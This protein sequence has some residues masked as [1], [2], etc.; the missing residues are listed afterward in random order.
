[1]YRLTLLVVALLVILACGGGGGGVV[2]V[3][4][5]TVVSISPKSPTVGLC[6]TQNFRATVT[7]NS[8]TRVQFTTSA[9]DISQSGSD[10]RFTA[11]STSG[12]VNVTARSVADTS[13][14]DTARV[15]VADLADSTGRVIDSLTGDGIPGIE[16]I[17]RNTSNT[18]VARLVTNAS[19]QYQGRVPSTARSLTLNDSTLPANYY[20]QFEFETKRYSLIIGGCFAPILAGCDCLGVISLTPNSLPPPPPPN[21]CS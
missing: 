10:A 18:V 15:N 21:G 7:G 3:P 16:V 4:T 6:C 17:F 9:G 13:A 2:D 12:T 1:M 19:G 8:D 11:P 14:Q 20:K 5:G